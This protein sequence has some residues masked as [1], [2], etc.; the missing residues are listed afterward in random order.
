M[1]RKRRLK[2]GRVN[3]PSVL[4]SVTSMAGH[5]FTVC[6]QLNAALVNASRQHPSDQVGWDRIPIALKGHQPFSAHHHRVEEAVV[7][8]QIR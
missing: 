2:M 7:S 1:P 4:A 8:C 5:S 6:E 3:D